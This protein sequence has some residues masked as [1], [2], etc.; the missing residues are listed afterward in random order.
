MNRKGEFVGQN[1]RLSWQVS[2]EVYVSNERKSPYVLNVFEII[3][4][5][6]DGFV[7]LA[8]TKSLYIISSASQV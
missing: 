4:W 7:F 1:F 8:F 3:I 5:E 6:Q 2:I